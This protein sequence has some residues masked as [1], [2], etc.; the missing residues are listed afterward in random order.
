MV[1]FQKPPVCQNNLSR[2]AVCQTRLPYSRQVY[3]THAVM[4]THGTPG[5]LPDVTVN[6]I[7]TRGKREGE[8][9]DY[10]L[11]ECSNIAPGLAE[12]P[13]THRQEER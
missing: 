13:Q 9:A 11:E 5:M 10:I 3:V 7:A 1:L 2:L 4:V 12:E 6:T 8:G